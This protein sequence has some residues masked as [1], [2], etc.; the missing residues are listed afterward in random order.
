MPKVVFVKFLAKDGEE[1]KWTLPG[2]SEPGVYPIAPMKKDWYLDKVRLHPVLHIKRRELLLTPVFAMTAHPAQGQTFIKGAI[3]DLN[4]GGS[5]SAMLARVERRNDLLMFR[6][7]PRHLFS[8]GQKQGPDLLLQVCRKDVPVDWPA[9]ER[10]YMP[11]KTCPG[12]VIYKYEHEYSTSDWG[13]KEN[14][15]NCFLC[16]DQRTADGLPFECNAFCRWKAKEAFL[17]HQLLAQS[18]HTRICDECL[19]RREC[20]VCKEN[21]SE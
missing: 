16:I 3:V 1:L 10:Q 14:R 2:R 20:I 15:G 7:F 17:K 11:H 8:Q 13:K 18:T 19:E 9:L 4:I 21:N 12:C 5:S 6:P